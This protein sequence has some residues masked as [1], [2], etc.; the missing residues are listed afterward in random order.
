MV[1]LISQRWCISYFS[2]IDLL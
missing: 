2:A 1:I